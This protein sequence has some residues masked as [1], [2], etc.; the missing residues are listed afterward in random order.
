MRRLA[1][2][3]AVLASLAFAA[4]G[5]DDESDTSGASGASGATGASGASS[6]MTAGEFLAAS[7]PDEVKAVEDLAAANDECEGVDAKAGGD[8][9]VAVAISAATAD[10]ET[11]LSEV[12]VEEC[13][14]S[15]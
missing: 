1:V 10:P 15:G 12:V 3:T 11:P 5:D 6:E 7:I 14:S 9:Q 2:L 13:E 8:F 4:C